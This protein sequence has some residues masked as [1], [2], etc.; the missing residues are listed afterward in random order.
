MANY[1]HSFR[2]YSERA[3]AAGE[4]MRNYLLLAKSDLTVQEARDACTYCRALLERDVRE[5]GYSLPDGTA[6]A[7]TGTFPSPTEYLEGDDD[8]IH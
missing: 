1:K 8:G 5:S 7:D 6:D 2:K 4:V 3:K